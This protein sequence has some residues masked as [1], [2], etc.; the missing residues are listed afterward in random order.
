MPYRFIY[1]DRAPEIW[2]LDRLG[3]HLWRFVRDGQDLIV[4]GHG[5]EEIEAKLKKRREGL[6]VIDY[7]VENK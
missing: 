7:F 6:M 1:N 3:N 4:Y 5:W 2:H